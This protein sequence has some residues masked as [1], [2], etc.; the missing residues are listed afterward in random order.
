MRRIVGIGALTVFL[1]TVPTA[2]RAE[3]A[4]YVSWDC[5]HARQTPKSI[6][7]ACADA[8]WYA[9]HLT[10]GFWGT[11]RASGTGAFHANDCI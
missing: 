2:A 10:W 4:T 11:N 1:A 7:L 5:Q 8:G 9:K 3:G 6:L